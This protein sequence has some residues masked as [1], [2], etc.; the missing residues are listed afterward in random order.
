MLFR[1]RKK[2]GLYYLLPGMARSNRRHNILVMRWSI[3][4]GIL[5]SILF[6]LLIYFLNQ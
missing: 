4:F 6:G 2:R 5:F 3:A 1:G